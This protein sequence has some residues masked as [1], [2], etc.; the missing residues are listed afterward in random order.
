MKVYLGIDPSDNYATF[1]LDYENAMEEYA[2]ISTA[3]EEWTPQEVIDYSDRFMRR[4]MD[5]VVQG[6]IDSGSMVL[7]VPNDAFNK[8]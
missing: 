8:K 6:I 4:G 7:S 3:P 2:V 1:L 5:Y